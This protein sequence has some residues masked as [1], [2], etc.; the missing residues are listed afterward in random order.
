MLLF[1]LP[2]LSVL[3]ASIALKSVM[4]FFLEALANSSPQRIVL[5]ISS[6][7]RSWGVEA[8]KF[9]VPKPSFALFNVQLHLGGKQGLKVEDGQGHAWICYKSPLSA[10]TISLRLAI[11]F[12][13]GVE[14][15]ELCSHLVFLAAG[16]FQMH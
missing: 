15:K 1:F 3:S 4:F 5:S 2:H 7:A 12:T 14:Q 11:A 6:I 16:V 9:G 10:P 8:P 13:R